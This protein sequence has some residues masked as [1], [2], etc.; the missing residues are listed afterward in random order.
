MLL[1]P[2]VA[3]IVVH[4]YRHILTDSNKTR[5]PKVAKYD[6]K[7]D[8]EILLDIL[9]FPIQSQAQPALPDSS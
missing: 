7:M 5:F 1:H 4:S 2:F 9:K 8:S 3:I 6:Y